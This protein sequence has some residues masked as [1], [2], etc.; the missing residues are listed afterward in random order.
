MNNAATQRFGRLKSSG[1]AGE[2]GIAIFDGAGR[3]I[4]VRQSDGFFITF[5]EE[6]RGLGNIFR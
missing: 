1:L 3:G 5:L 6:P 2:R 4:L